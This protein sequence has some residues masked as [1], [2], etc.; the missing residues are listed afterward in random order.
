[1]MRRTAGGSGQAPP[2]PPRAE[3]AGFAPVASST[4]LA[5][6]AAVVVLAGLV[7]FPAATGAEPIEPQEAPLAP[8]FVDETD[9][10]EGSY[11]VVLDSDPSDIGA[12]AA[13]D[14][15]VTAA[16]DA[17]ATI[18]HEFDELLV[19][20]AATMD[21]DT[22]AA[23]R[24]DPAVAYIE[25]DAVVSI[26][27]EQTNAPWGLD[28]SDQRDLPLDDR[29]AYEQTGAGVDAYIIDTGILPD[30]AELGGRVVGGADFMNDGLG[31]GD[32]NGHGTHVAGTV[33]A[34]TYGIAKGVDLYSV[35]V[36]DCQGSGTV[37]GVIAGMDWAAANASG[38]SVA[39]LS[40]GG[41]RS[42]T[43]ENAVDRLT[44]AGVV[45]VVVAGNLGEDAC[46]T[47]P[48]SAA[49]AIT[50]AASDAGDARAAFSNY[51]SCVDLFAPGVDVESLGHTSPTATRTMSGTSMASPHVAGV[52]AL[53]LEANPGASPAAVT[54]AILTGATP[55]V[56][57]DPNGSPN[58]LLYAPL[59][60][61][62]EPEP[63]RLEGTVTTS[64]DDPAA[65]I[66]IDIFTQA[67]DGSRARW[68]GDTVTEPNGAFSFEVDA[69]C[70]VLTFI[71]PLGDTF[72]GSGRW[73]EVPACVDAGQTAS[74]LDAVLVVPVD[75]P[76][77]IAGTVASGGVPVAAVTVDLFVA[78]ADG[79]R[80][81]WLGDARTDD[82]GRFVHTAAGG[83]YVLTF[84]APEGSLFDN[85]S[86]WYQPS[87]C[88]EA[89]QTVD[90]VD[91]VLQ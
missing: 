66:V 10:V 45:V 88:V 4:L 6:H 63:G 81:T 46:E 58:L 15:V 32:C 13:A 42:V 19:G 41:P 60:T 52:A 31:W 1:M 55:G 77:T 49:D 17:G 20:F 36:L 78:N 84:I 23:L 74:S 53:Y 33:G 82:A 57:T 89:G 27:A 26:G 38:P 91:A 29:Y 39:N 79:S 2:F 21:D 3:R 90:G 67:A 34:S 59:V 83:C 86:R 5:V 44:S 76:G 72:V 69:G 8:L 61:P 65:G 12:A 50:V 16:S 71:A 7:V 24:S 11:L 62:P 22:V 54:D 48:A 85:G 9:G 87:V 14:E 35:R 30:H 43:L 25:Q 37:S 64:G 47:S 56:I 75:G 40:L 51:G 68:L 28:R 18:E 70:Y 73:L 80:S